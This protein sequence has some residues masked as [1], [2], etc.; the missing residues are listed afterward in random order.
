[1]PTKT[2]MTFGSHRYAQCV[3]RITKEAE[4]INVFDTVLGFTDVDLKA[5]EAFWRRHGSFIEL[6]PVGYGYWVWKSYLIQKMLHTLQ[7]GDYL[8]YCDSGCEVNSGG[9]ARLLE[10]F[11]LLDNDPL[12]YGIISFELEHMEKKWTKRAIFEYF[13]VSAEPGGR[14]NFVA[15]EAFSDLVSRIMKPYYDRESIQNSNQFVGGI[16]VMKKTE[17]LMCL[18][19]EWY[20]TVCQYHLLDDSRSTNEY[21]EFIDN[22]H[23]QSLFSVLRKLRG[24]IVLKDETYFHYWVGSETFPFL[25]KRN[26]V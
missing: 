7:D 25:A 19:Q 3:Q 5:D 14:E 13:N 8:V 21:P 4:N 23:D 10:Y 6:N 24:S 11:D 20:D 18:I 9:R 15:D 16:L 26:K 12:N 17:H 2:F 1:M 22:R